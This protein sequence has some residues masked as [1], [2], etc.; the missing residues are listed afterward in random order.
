MKR[1]LIAV[2]DAAHAR[3][4]AYD[5]DA[6]DQLHEIGDLRSADRKLQ[7]GEPISSE[8]REAEV[9]SKFARDV[10][11]A[12]DKLVQQDAHRG[13]I[14]ATSTKML[15]ELRRH[16]GVLHRADVDI[17]EIPKILTALS[18]AQLHDHLATMDLIAPRRRLAAAR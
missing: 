6:A 17:H 2:M 7:I 4:F 11:Q 14:L 13:L 12:L 5:E 1:A 3:L 15:G 9:D 10:V 16:D 8:P 18:V